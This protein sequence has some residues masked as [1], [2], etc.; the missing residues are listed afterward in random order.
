MIQNFLKVVDGALGHGISDP[1]A[2]QLIP[3]VDGE[4]VPSTV[5]NVTK[6]ESGTPGELHGEFDTEKKSGTVEKN[7]DTGIYGHLEQTDLCGGRKA[8]PICKSDEITAGDAQ[9]L[10]T[11]C[12]GDATLYDI[13]ILKVADGGGQDNKD[14]LIQVTDPDL[15]AITGGIVQGLSGS[16]IIQ[17]GKI[18]GAVTHVLV[19]DPTRGYGIFI[20]NM[21]TA[22]S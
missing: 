2:Q 9:I 17:N 6:G 15:L 7:A 5:N 14:M 18:V 1:D 20:E 10:S 3:I 21:L 4:L 8:I 19:S 12:K 16:P 11:V 22:A 13:R